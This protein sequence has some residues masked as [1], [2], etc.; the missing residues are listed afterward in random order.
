[1][2]GLF[3]KLGGVCCQP[4]SPDLLLAITIT[5]QLNLLTLIVGAEHRGIE[6]VSAN[7]DGIIVRSTRRPWHKML[8]IVAAHTKKTGFEYGGWGVTARWRSPT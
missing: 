5:G 2:N 4:S 8:K 6:V 3:G 1:M 7:T